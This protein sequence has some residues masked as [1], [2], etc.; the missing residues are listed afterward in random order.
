MHFESFLGVYHLHHLGDC[1]KVLPLWDLLMFEV[2]SRVSLTKTTKHKT[3]IHGNC[4]FWSFLTTPGTPGLHF[5]KQIS[6]ILQ[7]S[8]NRCSRSHCRTSEGSRGRGETL[9]VSLASHKD[10]THQMGSTLWA[11]EEQGP[12]KGKVSCDF[13][14]YYVYFCLRLLFRFQIDAVLQ[15]RWTLQLTSHTCLPSK[16]RLEVAAHR[17]YKVIR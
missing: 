8:S 15:T 4:T 6:H 13:C 7:L 12:N 9:C 1:K 3:V 5:R 17:S 2:S 10:L 16:F 11:L 14:I